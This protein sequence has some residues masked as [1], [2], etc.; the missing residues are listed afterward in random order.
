M[1]P[2]AHLALIHYQVADIRD[3]QQL[4]YFVEKLGLS[5]TD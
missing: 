2:G 4:A 1:V 5:V 3:R